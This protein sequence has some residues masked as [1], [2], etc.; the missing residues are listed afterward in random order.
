MTMEYVRVMRQ[1]STWFIFLAVK[2]EE[3]ELQAKQCKQPLET[4]K[5]MEIFNQNLCKEM[6][7]WC[8]LADALV[9]TQ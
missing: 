2:V 7:A 1:R 4:K 9:L 8:S 6:Q 3:G 5:G